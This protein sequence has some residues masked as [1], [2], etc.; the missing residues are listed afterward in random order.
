MIERLRKRARTFAISA[1][2][3]WSAI[4]VASAIYALSNREVAAY[5]RASM[6]IAQREGR[7]EDVRAWNGLIEANGFA[8][9]MYIFVSLM[10]L[11][12]AI[13]TAKGLSR[14]SRSAIEH[15][16]RQMKPDVT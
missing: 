15:E 13:S 14:V 8:F 10:A 2:L 16:A 4:A 11:G 1:L 6:D 7:A 12:N 5:N 9:G 3:A